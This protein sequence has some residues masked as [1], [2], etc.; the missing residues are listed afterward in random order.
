MTVTRKGWDEQFMMSGFTK[1]DAYDG[2]A[3]AMTATHAFSLQ[4]FTTNIDWS[5][6]VVN[7]KE[8]VT[9]VEHGTDQ[10]ITTKGVTITLTEPKAKPNTVAALATAV[11]GTCVTTKDA[12]D[13]AY[14]HKIQPIAHGT[15]LPSFEVGSKRGSIQYQYTGVKANSIKLSGEEGGFIQC[16]AELWGSGTRAADA[17]AF[18]AIITESWMRL[19]NASL[20]FE[21]GANI[22]ITATLLQAAEDISSA[23]PDDF[24]VRIKNFE[25]NFSNNLEKQIGFGGL[26]VAQDIDFARRTATLTFTL[27]FASATAATEFAY[28]V[29]QDACAFELDLKGSIIDLSAPGGVP[30]Y[31]G[32]QII[33]PR[34][35]LMKAVLPQGGASDIL[36]QDFELDIQNDGTNSAA[37]IEVYNAQAGNGVSAVQA[38]LAASA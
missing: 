24:G 33:V 8:E 17:T 25:F 23:T 37:I 18:P 20:F 1:E 11:F 38:Y 13:D 26:G 35:K 36:T 7:D 3:T 12:A 28:Y 4:G 14:R 2:G 6:E 5:D 21:T 34:G 30:L 10:E 32:I 19:E 15:A 31:Y 22:S 9:G 29:D 16:E 27:N